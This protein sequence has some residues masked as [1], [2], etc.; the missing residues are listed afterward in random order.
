MNRK[1]PPIKNL[2]PTMART[3]RVVNR[4]ISHHERYHREQLLALC[5]MDMCVL[6]AEISRLATECGEWSDMFEEWINEPG[7]DD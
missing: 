4:L 7:R 2:E 3:D 1:P 5:R 6:L